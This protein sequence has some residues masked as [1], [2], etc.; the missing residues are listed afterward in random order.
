MIQ[1]YA[2]IKSVLDN[3]SDNIAVIDSDGKIVYV[4]RSWIVFGEKNQLIAQS[5]YKGKNYL[6]V[7]RKSAHNGD[8]YATQALNGIQR[9]IQGKTNQF[10][11]EYPCH[12]LEEARWF[13]MS[14]STFTHQDKSYFTISHRNITK[15]KLAEERA[16][17]LSKTD[18]LTGIANRR[19]FNNFFQNEWNRC[20]RQNQP[21]S[22]LILDIDL[23][24]QINDNY[25]HQMGDKILM[26]V[27][28]LLHAYSKRPS[29]LCARYGGDEFVI[30]LG[31]T[32]IQDA[33]TLATQLLNDI[34]S[35][36]TEDKTPDTIIKI[37]ATIGVASMIAD[38]TNNPESLL[39]LADKRL[40]CAKNNGRNR[41]F[42]DC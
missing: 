2:F 4:N 38:K 12:S 30:L 16:L 24:K 13:I 18:E 28:K 1:S 14:V 23:F 42:S 6:E 8:E 40:Y 15:R 36:R 32:T 10:E 41:V 34:R 20:K 39:K 17:T 3:V 27:S 37:T 31:N 22:L 19:F 5:S 9:F 29:D 11:L 35:L 33:V 25:G 21:I 26:K 7:C